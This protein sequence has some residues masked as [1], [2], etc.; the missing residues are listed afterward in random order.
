MVL[1]LTCLYL[2]LL[3]ILDNTLGY[4]YFTYA[5]LVMGIVFDLR[6]LSTA[7]TV[8][9]Y[10]SLVTAFGCSFIPRK[11]RWCFTY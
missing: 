1:V 11:A 10:I 9:V 6:K 8:V 3:V 5:L 2:G 4:G 7:N